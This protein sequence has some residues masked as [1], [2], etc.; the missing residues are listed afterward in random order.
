MIFDPC[1]KANFTVGAKNS[2]SPKISAA[3]KMHLAGVSID[4][5][6]SVTK[7]TL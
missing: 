7:F 5:N 6:G 1:S 3:R 2:K 4:K